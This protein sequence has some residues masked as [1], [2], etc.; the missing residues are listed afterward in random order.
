[1]LV[2]RGIV[3][4]YVRNCLALLAVIS[5]LASHS[6][7]L[8]S[9]TNTKGGA[10]PGT[11]TIR[12]LKSI[13]AKVDRVV[14]DMYCWIYPKEYSIRYKMDVTLGAK[15]DFFAAD[16]IRKVIQCLREGTDITTMSYFDATGSIKLFVGDKLV[17]DIKTH[18]PH[19]ISIKSDGNVRFMMY[20]A[21]TFEGVLLRLGK[22]ADPSEQE[23]ELQRKRK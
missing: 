6:V 8:H 9:S 21:S 4:E 10:D 19:Y 17:A 15:T 11:D 2:P 12:P 20:D 18:Q 3:N 14:V 23:F 13:P 22:R 1:M 7:R 5:V 16:K